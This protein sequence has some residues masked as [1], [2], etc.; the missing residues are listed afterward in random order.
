MRS[1]AIPMHIAHR[2]ALVCAVI[3]TL[4]AALPPRPVL[5]QET[6]KVWIQLE[7]KDNILETRDRARFFARSFPDTHA[8]LTESGWYAVAIGPM[9]KAEAKRQLA[10]LKTAGLIPRDSFISDGKTYLTQLWPLVAAVNIPTT[11]QPPK[12]AQP[13]TGATQEATGQAE[14]QQTAVTTPATTAAPTPA[15]TKTAAAPT[16]AKQDTNVIT[17]KQPA[18]QADQPIPD[19]DLNATRRAERKWSREQKKQY[20]SWL[21]WTG[22]YDAAIDGSYGPGTRRA[23]KAFQQ[24]EGFQPTGYLTQQQVEL[25]KQRH[26]QVMASLGVE[27]MRNEDA[28]IE[29]LFPSKLVTFDR[30][31][32]PFVRYKPKN[33][34][35]VSMMLISQQGGRDMLRGLY[36]IMETFDTI[37]PKGYRKLRRDWFVLTGRDDRIVSYT[38]A[39]TNNGLIKGFS[40]VWPVEKDKL[41]QPLISAMYDSFNPLDE[42]VLDENLGT[43]QAGKQPVDLSKGMEITEPDRA[44]TAFFINSDGTLVTEA[45]N[46][47]GCARLSIGDGTPVSVVYE[48]SAEKLAILK[49]ANG[50]TPPAFALFSGEGAKIGTKVTVSGFSFPDV[51]EA[52]ALNYGTVTDLRGPQGE[53]NRIRVSAFLERGDVGGPVLDE[54]GAVLGMALPR[55]SDIA[56]MPEY[57]NFAL[58]GKA[59]TDALNSQQIRYGIARTATPADPVDLAYMAADFTAKLACWKK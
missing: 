36:D 44:A 43:D 9:N 58:T 2:V 29:I 19:P 14:G 37:P 1:G 23:I 52:A 11:T 30:F 35:G 49:P 22:D 20:Q 40:L 55:P 46:I 57:V 45:D 15:T 38:Y 4:L 41:I 47:Y 16:P 26:D 59:I 25:L 31:D 18:Q 5:A 17:P 28:G 39:R 7:S 50:F 10:R 13:A 8:F 48:N 42:F 53:D 51:M 6:A 3:I 32:P 54:R 21:T 34:S 12:P 24:R 27:T 33:G 56:D